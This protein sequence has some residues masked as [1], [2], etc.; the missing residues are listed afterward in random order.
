MDIFDKSADILDKGIET[1]R[2]LFKSF[3]NWT[4]LAAIIIVTTI[5]TFVVLGIEDRLTKEV[6]VNAG[7]MIFIGSVTMFVFWPQGES[8][9]AAK[10]APYRDNLL[11]WGEYSER[12][13]KEGK[14]KAFAEFCK[15]KTDLRL[16]SIKETLIMNAGIELSEYAQL[17][18]NCTKRD[19]RKN[20][21]LARKQK[22][23]IIKAKK[24]ISIRPYNHYEVLAGSKYDY[25]AGGIS[26]KTKL[27]LRRIVFT[28]VIAVGGSVITFT[29]AD[30]G[31]AAIALYALRLQTIITS[32]IFGFYGG[33]N[34]IKAD[35]D[36]NK[37]K[38]LFINEFLE[39]GGA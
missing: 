38:I 24:N 4:L 35:N 27:L 33:V 30:V 19:I 1:G 16:K 25:S 34:K 5:L 10:N 8:N 17:Y 36:S 13:R 7:I 14:I 23:L 21:H 20:K 39:Q 37:A 15:T 12:V 3:L 18:Q 6:F 29:P 11:R 26:I 31:W 28:V 2:N 9:E 32:A 22:K